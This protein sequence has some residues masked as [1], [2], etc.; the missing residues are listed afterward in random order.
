MSAADQKRPLRFKK[1]RIAWSAFCGVACVLLLALW[2][3][4]Y[5]YWDI[6]AKGWGATPNQCVRLDSYSGAFSMLYLD[7]RNDSTITFARWKVTTLP[8]A[9]ADTF[10]PI[11]GFDD[12][13]AGFLYKRLSDGFEIDLPYWFLAPI[14]GLCAWLP[15]QRWPRTF[16]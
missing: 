9:K 14:P 15:W 8:S 11:G 10:V 4:S 1:L 6:V 16:S 13:Y 5:W 3:R 7:E 12:G 2:V